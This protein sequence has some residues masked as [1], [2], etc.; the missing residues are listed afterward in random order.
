MITWS[1][2]L[3]VTVLLASERPACMRSTVMSSGASALAGRAKTVCN[4]FTALP[5]C[6]ASAAHDRLGQ[7]LPS[8]DHAV[9][10][11]HARRPVAV[12]ADRLERQRLD[13]RVHREHR[14]LLVSGSLHLSGVVGLCGYLGR[15]AAPTMPD[16]GGPGLASGIPVTAE[17]R[18]RYP[19]WRA[20]ITPFLTTTSKSDTL[21]NSGSP[22]TTRGLV[23]G[24]AGCAVP[25]WGVEPNDGEEEEP[26]PRQ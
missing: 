1:S 11:L 15:P 20:M 22:G 13:E 23:P 17:R 21:R 10:A 18:G 25:S 16:A 8:P 9:V 24:H 2:W 6:P 7:Q 3:M 26:W 12:F 19:A 14:G 4:V 5:S